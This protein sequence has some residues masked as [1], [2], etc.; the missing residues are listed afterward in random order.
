MSDALELWDMQFGYGRQPVVRDVSLRVAAGDCY[1][2]LGHNGAGKTTVMRLCLGLLRP[3]RGAVRVC[4]ADPSLNRRQANALVG[5]LIERPGF[6]LHGTARQN[7]TALAQ[8][9]GMARRLANAEVERVVEAVGLR[10][11][12]DR[13]VGTFSMGMKQ[14]LGI[15]QAL[16][17]RPKLLLLD[18]PTNGLD[19][20]GIAEL[21]ALLRRMTRE[22]GVAVLLSSHQLAELDGLC[23]RVGVL[24]DGRVVAEGD[25]A[26]LRRQVGARHV[27]TGAPLEGLEHAL[28]E[29]GLTSARDGDRVLVDIQD[30]PAAAI[31]R[32]LSASCELTSF[33]PE[34]ATLERIYLEAARGA[35]PPPSPQQPAPAAA[36]PPAPTLG[37]ARAPR[38]RSFLYESTTLLYRRAT[39]PLVLLPCVVAVFSVYRYGQDVA[40]GLALVEAGERFSADAG[41]GHLAVARSLQAATPALALAMLWFSS[42]TIAADDAADTLRNSLVRSLRRQD[43][44]FGKLAVL[45]S[46]AM[47]GWAGLV[48]VASFASW[49][50]V[51]FGDLEEVS[52]VGDRDLLA[53]AA[54]VT[55]TLLLT[56]AQMALP[57]VAVVMIGAMAS[58]LARRPAL[59]LMTAAALTL[60]PDLARV[61]LPGAGGWLLTSH[62]PMPWRDESALAYA[63]ASARGAAD[64]LWLHADLAVWAPLAWIAAAT[65]VLATLFERMRIR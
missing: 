7:L 24:R 25:L 63:G 62:L 27:V 60:A 29:R 2:F 14:R 5:A 6:H 47:L 8:L 31:T 57:L 33:A 1:G 34:P 40:E 59:A 10:A 43:V 15:A 54:D 35:L 11:Q 38:R 48:A 53:A 58:A 18:E 12:I 20:E 42:Q 55:P 22:E 26:H 65:V 45:L 4:G 36:A 64:A 51:G 49:A 46:V 13:R 23:D 3:T 16:L 50:T 56:I 39:L 30:Q 32:E 19:P 41:S 9:Q 17:G 37:R 61:W 21:R 28:R 44:L 52:R